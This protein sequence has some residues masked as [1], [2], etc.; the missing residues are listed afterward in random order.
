MAPFSVERMKFLYERT[1]NPVYVWLALRTIAH[2]AG[3]RTERDEAAD[4]RFRRDGHPIDDERQ[5][6]NPSDA[7]IPAWCL[8]YLAQSAAGLF[9]L[10]R[11]YDFRKPYPPRFE[12]RHLAHNDA[13]ELV[14]QALGL[15]RRGWNAFR[16]AS[17]DNAKIALALQHEFQTTAKGKTARTA[18]AALRWLAPVENERSY[19]RSVAEGRALTSQERWQEIVEALRATKGRS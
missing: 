16:Q 18:M 13:M 9:D 2:A 15:S 10:Q 6:R 11:G 8:A 1:G 4:D 19:A 7:T 14:P 3:H 12:G 5:E 17:S